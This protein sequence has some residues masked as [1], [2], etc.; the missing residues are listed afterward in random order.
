MKILFYKG[1]KRENDK[2]HFVDRLICVITSS[3]YSHVEL[4]FEQRGSYIHRCWSSSIRPDGYGVREKWIDTSTGHWDIIETSMSCTEDLFFKERN[5][6]YD[7]I[8]LLGTIFNTKIFSSDHKWFCSEIIAEAL[9]I[10][11]SWQQSPQDLF[12]RFNRRQ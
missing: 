10:E 4:S 9:G 7:F 3:R 2:A 11:K 8:G 12:E 5:S 1:T 6:K